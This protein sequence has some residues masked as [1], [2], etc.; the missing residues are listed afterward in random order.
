M[1]IKYMLFMWSNLNFQHHYSS[2][3]WSFR[4]HYNMLISSLRNITN[5]YQ[6]WKLFFRILWWIESS[7]EEYL[8]KILILY[9]IINVL[10]VTFDQFNA[11]FLNK[12]IN[13]FWKYSV[14]IWW[15]KNKF[16]FA[17]N[18]DDYLITHIPLLLR[19][20]TS[21]WDFPVFTRCWH[22][23]AGD[24]WGIIF[25]WLFSVFGFDTHVLQG[26]C[27]R[28]LR[29]SALWDWRPSIDHRMSSRSLPDQNRPRPG[30]SMGHNPSGPSVMNGFFIRLRERDRLHQLSFIFLFNSIINECF[31]LSLIRG[32]T[33]RVKFFMSLGCAADFLCF[34]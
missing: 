19:L 28:D 17:H 32:F 15:L 6:C 27:G 13:F 7:N 26:S 2:V 16:M 10:T 4:N 1:L 9:N 22:F 30:G 5:Y 18:N 14:R 29:R 21:C 23:L 11:F 25:R 20:H 34:F 33:V 31:I 24:W 3:T 12:S 8:F